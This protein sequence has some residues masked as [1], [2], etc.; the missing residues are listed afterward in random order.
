MKFCLTLC[1]LL[2]SAFCSQVLSAPAGSDTTSCC[3][4][5]TPRQI[6]RSHVQE[7]YYTSSR[8]S[9]PAVVFV[10]RKK[11]EICT[12]PE[13]KWVQDYVNYLEMN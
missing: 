4:G 3:F 10:T 1:V 6:P 5:Y 12:N 8:C 11:R 9:Q 13:I 7:Y 2:L